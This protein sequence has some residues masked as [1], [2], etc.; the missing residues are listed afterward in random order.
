MNTAEKIRTHIE[1]Q[2]AKGE[3]ILQMPYLIGI[4][5]KARAGKSEAASFLKG[6]HR[7]DSDSFA[8][9]IK[10]A[11]AELF[12]FDEY[13][14]NSHKSE[15]I[16]GF[17]VV[18]S[19]ELYQFFGTELCRTLF[20]PNFFVWN[21]AAYYKSC[22]SYQHFRVVY[23]DIRFQEE[24]D[25]ILECGGTLIHLTRKGADGKVGI[26]DHASEQGYQTTDTKLYRKG[27]NY[28]EVENNGTVF[29]LG[30]QINKVLA[31]VRLAQTSLKSI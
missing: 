12:G 4:S 6:V 13:C 26:P 11:C 27:E 30:Y 2:I 1:S 19:R 8:A 20:G 24:A 14:Y 21:E 22:E 10:T 18:T 28:Y 15:P 23:D 9:R 5:G 17:E 7:Y 25:W 29:D 31:A 16:A 3:H